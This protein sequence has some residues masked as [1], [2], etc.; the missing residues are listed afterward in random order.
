MGDQTPDPN[1]NVTLPGEPAPPRHTFPCPLCGTA[2]DL[3][4]SRAQ[5]PYCVCDSCGL[6]VFFRGKTGI[7]RLRRWLAESGRL[8]AGPAAHAAAAVTVF[9]RLEH[10]RA[11]KR[12]L[13]QRRGLLFTDEDLEHAIAAVNHDIERLR[14]VLDEMSDGSKS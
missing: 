12:E 1:V 8:A 4:Q 9:N 14:R 2:L 5:K 13:E 10:L 7:A 3:R 6:Q 11:Q